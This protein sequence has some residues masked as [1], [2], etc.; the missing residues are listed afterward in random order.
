[1]EH[2]RSLSSSLICLK[3]LLDG[4][5][6]IL[7]YLSTSHRTEKHELLAMHQ[8]MSRSIADFQDSIDD[9]EAFDDINGRLN[10]DDL[11][12][13][14]YGAFAIFSNWSTLSANFHIPQFCT[15]FSTI[16]YWVCLPS[17]GEEFLCQCKASHLFRVSGTFAFHGLLG[18]DLSRAFG[19]FERLDLFFLFDPYLLKKSAKCNTSVHTEDMNA[20]IK[21]LADTL[22]CLKVMAPS[23]VVD[24]LDTEK[25]GTFFDTILSNF[26][27]K[28]ERGCGEEI[29]RDWF[30]RKQEKCASILK[31]I[32]GPITTSKAPIPS[33]SSYRVVPAST[34][35]KS[36]VAVVKFS[37]DTW[38]LQ[39]IN[40][41]RKNHVGAQIK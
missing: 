1:M 16:N 39:H 19:G 7:V 36:I 14:L 24:S 5:S 22:S 32:A 23:R 20:K 30:S 10:T 18:S 13:F 38:R 4:L 9:Q 21:V 27:G 3:A 8:M 35:T 11:S 26:I 37:N 17:I 2:A 25:K 33:S 41:I 34:L 31:S 15:P 40:N 6:S 29:T 12:W 28:T